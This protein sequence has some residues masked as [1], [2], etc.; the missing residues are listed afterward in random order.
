VLQ[1]KIE[2]I[3]TGRK[4]SPE[5]MILFEQ[6]NFSQKVV[7]VDQCAHVLSNKKQELV[8]GANTIVIT[9]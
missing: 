7:F 9:M 6:A 2:N 1:N 8:P 5:K 3:I 4:P